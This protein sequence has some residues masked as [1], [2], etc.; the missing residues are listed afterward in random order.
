[1]AQA[2]AG[3]A[4]EK[5]LHCG[6][7]SR[8]ACWN[9][10]KIICCFSVRDAMPVSYTEMAQHRPAL[11]RLLVSDYHRLDGATLTAPLGLVG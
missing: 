1:M 2:Q 4:E 9:A 8:S 3:A 7:S 11:F 6:W 10:S 5:I